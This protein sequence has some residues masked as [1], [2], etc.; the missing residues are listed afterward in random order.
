MK[1]A[2]LIIITLFLGFT[3]KSQDTK[4]ESKYSSYKEMRAEVVKLFKE[5]KFNDAAELIDKEKEFYPDKIMSNCFNQALCYTSVKNY[6]KGV[7]S[8]QY[9]IDKGLWFGIWD[10]TAPRWEP[11]KEMAKF[12]KIQ[13][14]SKDR[15][16][17]AEKKTKPKKYI[18]L[19]DNYDK[20]KK[21][22]LFIALHGGNGNAKDFMK[23]WKSEKLKKEFI[24]A[25]LQ[26]S[27]LS[28]MTGF[29][30][31]N[32]EKTKK[33]VK[34]AYESIIEDYKI[35]NKN[36]I[37]GGFSDG[38]RASLIIS[39]T[40]TVKSKGFF[41]LCPPKPNEF[42]NDLLDMSKKLKLKGTILTSEMDHNLNSQKEMNES[43]KNKDFD[44]KFIVTPNIG[45]WFPKDFD[46]KLD[47]GLENILK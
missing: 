39:M 23:V 22:P 14:I 25:Y 46:K 17:E 45:H 38:G 1:A 20:K 31:M 21:Y 43:F 37:I 15:R 30:W 4:T 12:K 26:S 19:P 24:I 10:L 18:V 13:E 6:E 40:N 3:L 41:V 35:D 47:E 42:N 29:T 8:L 7:L 9:V 32:L 27:Q 44:V 28:S 33:E 5:K 2:S 34:K 36:V 16:L 11:Y